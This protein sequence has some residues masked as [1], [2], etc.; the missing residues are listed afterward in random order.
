M[1]VSSDWFGNFESS[2]PHRK[3][4]EWR[5]CQTENG[6]GTVLSD[7]RL[8]RCCYEDTRT[9][10]IWSSVP[11]MQQLTTSGFVL[12]L[13]CSIWRPMDTETWPTY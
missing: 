7:S 5:R 2:I 9:T 13:Q 12:I 8:A 10:S 6:N 11:L 4:L 3:Q 1:S